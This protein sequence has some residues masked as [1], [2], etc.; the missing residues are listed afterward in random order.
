MDTPQ[1]RTPLRPAS[2]SSS[3]RRALH[4]RSSEHLATPSR[5]SPLARPPTFHTLNPALVTPN[6]SASRYP[7]SAYPSP[8]SL[9]SSSNSH[10]STPTASAS[11][12]SALEPILIPTPKLGRFLR[13]LRAKLA[14]FRQAAS[15]APQAHR[16]LVE[17]P[18]PSH[19]PIPRRS[20]ALTSHSSSSQ[21]ASSSPNAPA[22]VAITCATS[23]TIHLRLAAS[24]FRHRL[25][26]CWPACATCTHTH[27]DPA[28]AIDRVYSRSLP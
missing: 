27:S 7:T 25:T 15:S 19:R 3:S 4:P 5:S 16:E 10:A 2:A 24:F 21:S 12:A 1:F 11:A 8:K 20:A 18:T 13:P 9:C 6:H 23:R 14:H 26:R 22:P 28:P 17:P